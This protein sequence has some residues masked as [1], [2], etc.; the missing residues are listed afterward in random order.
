MRDIN[1]ETRFAGA[2][3]PLEG[4]AYCPFLLLLQWLTFIGVL[5]FMLWAAWRYGFI[6]NIV[7]TDVTKL[8]VIIALIF[9]GGTV[10]CALRCMFLS[11]QADELHSLIA[12]AADLRGGVDGRVYLGAR[13]VNRSPIADYLGGA[14]ARPGRDED[15]L[16]RL[17]EVLVERLK[18]AHESGWFLAGLLVKL[19]L[20]GTVIGFIL[21]LTSISGVVT[22]DPSQIHL[23]FSEMTHG[24]RVALNTTLVG[25]V[26]TILLGFQ[27]LLLDRSAE[28]LLADAT[29]FAEAVRGRGANGG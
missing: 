12:E 18:G 6:Q 14:L 15:K 27:Y 5:A 24:M 22:L 19:G 2:S 13:P 3:N 20:L 8:S 29:H 1:T 25:L 7:S 21:M 26:G 28:R 10:H 9:A 23:F 16:S 4:G 17:Y 11:R